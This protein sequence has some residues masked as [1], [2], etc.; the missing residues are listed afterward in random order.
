MHS[1]VHR[2][3]FHFIRTHFGD[4]D[5]KGAGFGGDAVHW[6]YSFNEH[7][8]DAETFELVERSAR[9][10]AL[11]NDDFLEAFGAHWIS[12]SKSNG[13]GTILDFAGKDILTFLSNL[14]ALHGAAHV[15]LTGAITPTFTI[16]EQRPGF[17]Q[18]RYD[19]ER[20]GLDRFVLGLLKGLLPHFRLTGDVIQDSSETGLFIISYSPVC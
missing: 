9:I 8:P 3:L 16:L 10:F 18:L 7:F 1:F 2:A 12:F 11:S 19:S 15:S 14:N 13:Y 5:L 20:S 17:I 4:N 6:D